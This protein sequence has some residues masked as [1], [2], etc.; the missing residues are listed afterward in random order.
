MCLYLCC[1]FWIAIFLTFVNSVLE[2]FQTS[3]S[4]TTRLLFLFQVNQ[5][6]LTSSIPQQYKFTTH[7]NGS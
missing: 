2:S 5:E 1:E 3:V 7:Q 4:H 6:S